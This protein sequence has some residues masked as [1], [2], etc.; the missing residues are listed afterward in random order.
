MCKT[1]ESWSYRATGLD[2]LM[3]KRK[4]KKGMAP[5]INTKEII[6]RLNQKAQMLADGVVIKTKWTEINEN[7]TEKQK[8]EL[9]GKVLEICVREIMGNHV[10]MFDGQA[11]LQTEGGAIGLR[12]TG[13]VARVVMDRWAGKMK[14]KMTINYMEWYLLVKYVDDVYTFLNA[15]KKGMRWSDEE[16]KLMWHEDDEK[17][18]MDENNSDDYVTMNAWAGMAS[19]IYPFLKFTIDI[20]EHH[21]DK[22]VPV[23]DVKVWREEE[24]SVVHSF[25]EKPM[26]LDKVIM[27]DSAQQSHVKIATLSQEEVRRMKNVSR[28]SKT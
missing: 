1:C 26:V 11:Y 15:I 19:S 28:D 18:D 3:P 24:G 6:Q 7:I 23:L 22:C 2:M 25:Y 12:L 5:T 10:Y 4:F 13:L 9:M 8:S 21:I 27:A 16:D 20:P 14:A 17:Y